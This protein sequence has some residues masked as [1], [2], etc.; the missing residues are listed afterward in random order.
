[1][2]DAACHDAVA[3]AGELQEGG[4]LQRVLDERRAVV[5]TQV[6][7]MSLSGELQRGTGQRESVGE[8]GSDPGELGSRHN[9]SV[10]DARPS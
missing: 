3:I 6:A 2:Q 8:R 9:R 7:R 1:M 4:D 10:S 5:A